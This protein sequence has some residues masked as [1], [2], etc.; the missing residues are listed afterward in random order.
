VNVTT[1]EY[2]ENNTANWQ[3]ACQDTDGAAPFDC[4]WDLSGLEEKTTYEVRVRANDSLG[5]IGNYDNHTNISID[6]TSPIISLIGPA[7]NSQDVDGD[8]ILFEYNVTD[9]LLEI[10]NCN[11]IIN[12]TINQTNYSVVKNTIQNFTLSGMA[13]GNYTWNINCTD[14]A[15]NKNSSE[16]R[17]LIIAIDTDPPIVNLTSPINGFTSTVN[18]IT[19]QYNVTDIVSGIANCSLIINGTINQTNTTPVLE[20]EI[21][22]FTVNDMADG[23]YL[24]NITCTDTAAS[25]NIGTSTTFNL[26]IQEATTIKVNVSFDKPSYE[27]I[28]TNGEIANI[29]I[30]T[31]DLFGNVLMT[32]VTTSIIK[33]NTTI[34]WWNSSYQYRQ[35]INITNNYN[36]VLEAGYTINYT[37]NT[38]TLINQSKMQADGDDL[39]IAFWNN[40]SNT[41]IE[42]DRIIIDLNTTE[43]SILFRTQRNISANSSD[44]NYY[45]Y[46]SNNS[47]TNQPKNKSL[48]YFYYDSFDNNTLNNYNKSPAF[49]NVSLSGEDEDSTL[50]HDTA[51]RT[52]RYT[53]TQDYGKSIR[54][55]NLQ[56]KDLEIEVQQNLESLPGSASRAEFELGVRING[57]NYYFLNIPN[58]NAFWDGEIGRYNNGV[59]TVLQTKTL[60]DYAMGQYWNLKFIIYDI[61]SSTVSLRAYI[62]D[63]EVLAFNDSQINKINQSGGFGTGSIE[64]IGNWDNL[65]VK[66]YVPIQPTTT[67]G[68]EEEMVYFTSGQTDSNGIFSFNFN[69]TNQSYT[70]YSAV[71]LATK[72]PSYNNGVG[73]SIFEI[74]GDRTPPG[75][76]NVNTIPGIIYN[77]NNV[78]I[79]VDITDNLNNLD[80]E[81][82]IIE[83]NWTG[84]FVNYSV[85]NFTGN[86]YNYTINADNL[87]SSEFVVY[88]FY[89]N[90][91]QGNM[92]TSPFYNFTVVNSIA[93]VNITYPI[94]E[95]NRYINETF[96]L[97]ASVIAVNGSI[98]NCNV[99][100]IYDSGL[101][102]ISNITQNISNLTNGSIDKGPAWLF[103]GTTVGNYIINISSNCSEGDS[104]IANSVNIEIT[105]IFSNLSDKSYAER[106]IINNVK[107]YHISSETGVDWWMNNSEEFISINSSGIE[108]PWFKYKWYLILNNTLIYDFE[109]IT[110]DTQKTGIDSSDNTTFIQ[111]T[112]RLIEQNLRINYTKKVYPYSKKDN[113]SFFVENIGENNFSNLKLKWA[114]KE[115][116]IFNNNV[117]D[118]FTLINS[119]GQ[120]ESYFMNSS[121][122]LI[123]NQTNF[124]IPEIYFVDKNSN[125]RGYAYWEWNMST[126]SV[127]SSINNF[128][129]ETGGTNFMINLTF[130][131]GNLS[132]SQIKG[133]DPGAGLIT[134]GLIQR[135]DT[136]A[137]KTANES[138]T[139]Y[140]DITLDLTDN[141]IT[142]R[143]Y[144]MTKVNKQVKVL[145]I[146][147]NTEISIFDSIY[148]RVY[149]YS[150]S[151]LSSYP[152][153]L[154]S[155]NKDNVTVNTSNFVNYTF[156]NSQENSWVQF[157]ITEIAHLQDNWGYLRIRLSPNGTEI[158]NNRKIYFSEILFN[159]TDE[160]PPSILLNN[161]VNDFNTTNTTIIFNWTV[162]DKVD[163]NL[164]CNLTI[165]GTVN[166]SDVN[167]SNGSSINF[168][169]DNLSS[170]VHLWNVTCID[171]SANQNTSITWTFTVVDSPKNLTAILGND[172]ISII[173]NWSNVSYADSYN[174]YILDNYSIDFSSVPNIT[175]I[176]D[177][178]WTD[179]NAGQSK[180]RF[181]KVA[182]V[183]GLANK[184]TTKI[185][186]KYETEL[187]TRTGQ[188]TDWNLIS[189]PFN[190]TN[191]ELYNGTNNGYNPPVQPLNCIRAIW[192]YNSTAGWEKSEYNG[193]V[194]KPVAGD[195]NFTSLEAGKGYWFE[196]NKTCNLT[197][198]G[199][200]P[201]NN[202]NISLSLGWNIVAW[203]STNVS[204]LPMTSQETGWTQPEPPSW[205]INVSPD[206]AVKAINRYNTNNGKFE[207]TIHYDNNWGWWPS[208]GN[209]DFTTLDPTKGYYFDTNPTAIWQH[210]PNT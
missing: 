38:Q 42:L 18:D 152:V 27:S 166:V 186:G 51:T 181:Y 52:I 89:A 77:F 113:I 130:D 46:Y 183:R 25:P 7:N 154:Y 156:S 50:T 116:D 32:N 180:T 200:V 64:F 188:I 146:L 108:N 123:Y 184:T 203:Y 121:T 35:F 76:S 53:G 163:M 2:R 98:N 23:L 126:N 122:S 102:L 131:L 115:F 114:L 44:I 182:T 210:D 178:N 88:R 192:R 45:V 101:T 175:G 142:T 14:F 176:T 195:E 97:N 164:S 54:Y 133:L 60:N 171:D 143:D 40:N 19:F 155:Y 34:P 3:V 105:P 66:R 21:N 84:S 179:T 138:G 185:V 109:N 169:I 118:N 37:M 174:I 149:L 159:T 136:I 206:G 55:D 93:E 30:K 140:T 43:T 90:D 129:F 70:N 150:I 6:R 208:S 39:R 33:A 125:T 170:G 128:T 209:E 96:W 78:T 132:S 197:F 106:T 1:F 190:L 13:D 100:T 145:N 4:I 134:P 17:N 202:M 201:L 16:I 75:F 67:N 47:V 162:S 117:V 119:S 12:G 137:N 196:T 41:W 127:K 80:N 151:P 72:L 82:V 157:N 139:T 189:I 49:D 198:V 11:L 204:N 173:L 148:L 15:G 20:N 69:T 94:Y 61:N 87:S 147:N 83:G 5:F 79:L 111:Y 81:S 29:S 168:T 194:W 110:W 187:I 71:S 57:D 92:N 160:S 158:G 99:T 36:R 62:N 120:V 144:M 10:S 31:Q 58:E 63:T 91:T 165:D 48:V 141:D 191:Y 24:W 9:N 112:G 86:T 177:N 161:P 199:E 172:N 65:T 107:Y 85:L 8:N 26:T 74:T 103:N 205:P 135:T 73:Y 95:I 124:N 28:E 59:R 207:V 22:T 193:S 68:S 56:I 104:V 153:V 167:V